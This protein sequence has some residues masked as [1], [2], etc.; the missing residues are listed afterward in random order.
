M[1]DNLIPF[2]PLSADRVIV[3]IYDDGNK[4]VELSDGRKLIVGLQDTNFDSLH[5]VTDGKHPGI[6]PRW[7]I[8]TAVHEDGDG[9]VKV[10]DKVFLDTMKWRRGVLA[11]G[12]ARKIWDI[13]SEDILLVDD[14]GLDDDEMKIVSDY[15]VDFR[16]HG[17]S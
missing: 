3:F 9:E 13:K 5:D 1:S 6:R 12:G 7:A 8:V 10:G 4:S 17:V 15:L 11:G 2:R 16:V 14:N